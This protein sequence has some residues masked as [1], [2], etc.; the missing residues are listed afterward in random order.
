[1]RAIFLD[2]VCRLLYDFYGP[3][4]QNCKGLKSKPVVKNV[5]VMNKQEKKGQSNGPGL[6]WPR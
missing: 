5:Q 3:T 2:T 4:W 6:V 1:M